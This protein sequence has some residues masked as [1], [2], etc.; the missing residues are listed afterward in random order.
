M[1]VTLTLNPSLDRSI[2]IAAFHRGAVI[3]ATSTRLDPGGKGVN[4]ARA[5]AEHR[6]KT[7]AVLPAGGPDGTELTTLLSRSG[8]DVRAVPVSGPTRSNVSLIEP[9]GVVTKINE[10]GGR[11]SES[12]L[13]AVV[14]A[15]LAAAGGADWVVACGSLP[16]GTP[17]DSYARL[18][19]LLA[20]TGVRVALDSSGPALS[21]AV[22]AGPDLVKPN[23]TE[24]AE[25][26][27]TPVA[28]LGD[29][30]TSAQSMC[31]AGAGQV[32][33]SLGADGAL[34]VDR[35]GWVYGEAPA[36]QPVSTV[37]AGDAMLAGF[38]AAG[39]TGPE[40][41]REGLAWG[42]AAVA[43][44]GSRMPGP[45]D[46]DRDAVRIHHRPD[47]TRVLHDPH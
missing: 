43:Q 7:C 44:P 10:P 40:A 34:L 11:L 15:V 46:I 26:A 30:V 36:V 21:T 9:D 38:L 1:I 28:T 45:A 17:P 27:G 47:P 33:V 5:L 37:G 6:R 41:L 2:E 16:P 20:P 14:E 22:P 42:S 23:R 25:F 19:R 31:A 12:D 3:R 35:D 4:V 29:A 24:L 32:L 13:D 8:L 18:C 39:A